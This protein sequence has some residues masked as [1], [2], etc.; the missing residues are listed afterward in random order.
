MAFEH[1]ADLDELQDLG[2]VEADHHRA[3]V[4]DVAHQALGLQLAQRLADRHARNLEVAR[5]RHLVQLLAVG[6]LPVVDRHA[7]RVG[8]VV[9]GRAPLAQRRVDRQARKARRRDA[10]RLLDRGQS[11][12]AARGLG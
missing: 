12:K 5:E 2:E 10:E 7:H 6:E 3:A 4:R 1:C 9:G 8:D 11:P